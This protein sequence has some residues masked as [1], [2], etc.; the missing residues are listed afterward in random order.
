MTNQEPELLSMPP[1]L[2]I[3]AVIPARGG[4]KGIPRKNL[5]RLAGKPLL[6]HAIE[7]ARA[8]IYINRIV[9]STDDKEI[10]EVAKSFGAEQV[11][12]PAEISGDHSSSESALLDALAQLHNIDSYEPDLLVFLQCTSPLTLPEDI[13]GTI[14]TLL[15]KSADTAF[16]VT[17]FHYFL[18]REDQEEETAV[19]I[20]HE[21]RLRPLRQEK[22]PQYLETGAVYVMRTQGFR[23]AQHRFFGKTV[24]HVIPPER[25]LEIDEPV[26][27][28]V[29][30]VKMRA[31][32]EQQRRA[33]LP[34][35]IGAIVFDFDGVFSDNRVIVFD[36]G[37]EAVIC[38]RSD[39]L[40][41]SELKQLHIPLLVLSTERNP[42]VAARCRKLEIPCV[43][44]LTDKLVA[45]TQWLSSNGVNLSRTVYVGN[46]VNDLDCLEA[47]GCG[48]S[49]ADAHPRAKAASSVVL[50]APGGRGAIR[51]LCDLI[52]SSGT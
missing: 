33:M 47:A 14:Q 5:V 11:Q 1:R 41:L 9:V 26:D 22:E 17:P 40:G 6:A 45:L 50:S 28:L 3:L 42:V 36:D 30:E 24:M 15:S 34:E 32:D 10:A 44:G 8:S 27:L 19:A 37:R 38:D 51:E 31:R 20:N 18:W 29:A 16:A 48:I 25:C 4:S 12:R 43:Q 13:D 23:E 21:S 35:R 39:G 49:V 52:I 2:K 7:S 46:D